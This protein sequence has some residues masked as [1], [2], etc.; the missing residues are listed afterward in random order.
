MLTIKATL[1]KITAFLRPC[2]ELQNP[3]YIPIS[4]LL[5]HFDRA[6]TLGADS[7]DLNYPL[8]TY[9]VIKVLKDFIKLIA[10]LIRAVNNK[11]MVIKWPKYVGFIKKPLTTLLIVFEKI[12]M[13]RSALVHIY[14]EFLNQYWF[15]RYS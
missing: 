9:K 3:Y 8:K 12:E 10:K 4:L 15:F 6:T 11:P 13:N 2:L 1:I 14:L 5:D 7:I